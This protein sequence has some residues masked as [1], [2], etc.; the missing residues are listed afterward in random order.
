ML[1]IIGL[2]RT[3]FKQTEIG[4]HFGVG[5]SDVSRILSEHHQT[6]SA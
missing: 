3:G 1:P 4:N 2:R 6:E 5:Q